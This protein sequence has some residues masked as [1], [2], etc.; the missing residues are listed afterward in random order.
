MNRVEHPPAE[1]KSIFFFSLHK[2]ATSF[3]THSVLPRSCWHQQVDYQTDHYLDKSFTPKVDETGHIYGVLRVVEP[4]H[5]SFAL[6]EWMFESAIRTDCLKVILVRDP[7]DILVSMYFSFGAN[8]ERSHGF[9][10]NPQVKEYQEQ[11]IKMIENLSIDEYVVAES[12]VL[13]EKYLKLNQLLKLKNSIVLRYEDLINDFDGFY[14]QLSSVLPLRAGVEQDMYIETR[15]NLLE[16]PLAHKRSGKTYNFGEKLKDETCQVLAKNH[17][18]TLQQ[19]NYPLL[20]H[21][22]ET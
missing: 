20:N 14:A 12:E 22:N 7:R 5:P 19:F 16:N 15:P 6:A 10:P 9:S 18:D 3:F 8:H 4:Q 1:V 11:R 2:C 17:F 13:K 21:N